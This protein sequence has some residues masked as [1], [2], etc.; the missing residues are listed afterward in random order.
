MDR[1]PRTLALRASRMFRERPNWTGAHCHIVIENR[2]RE[3]TKDRRKERETSR[4]R[5]RQTEKVFARRTRENL[6]N[7]PV[8]VP[9]KRPCH[10]RHG[11]FNGTHGSVWKVHTGAFR[12]YTQRCFQCAHTQHSTIPNTMQHHT[13]SHNTQTHY[14]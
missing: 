7:A 2:K 1:G 9:S 14:T 11:R 3:P 5:E 10:T 8:C 6:Q 12:K 4:E 13:T